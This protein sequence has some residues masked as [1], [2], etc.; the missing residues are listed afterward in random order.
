[1][2]KITKMSVEIIK[3]D[4]YNRDKQL[5]INDMHQYNGYSVNVIVT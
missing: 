4:I 2:N 1:M 5:L 3:A